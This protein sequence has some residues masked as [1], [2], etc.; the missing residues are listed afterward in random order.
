[1]EKERMVEASM[2]EMSKAFHQAHQ[3]LS[4]AVKSAGDIA[5]QMEGG[6]L[7][8]DAGDEFRA[9]IQNQFTQNVNRLGAK[10]MEMEGDIQKAVAAIH[11]EEQKAQSRF[12]N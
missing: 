12:Q 2:N 1:M 8:G 6:A 11:Q 3:T 4:E 5:K 7:L 10:V 9:A